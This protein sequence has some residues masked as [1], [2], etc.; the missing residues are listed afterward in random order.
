M[1]TGDRLVI[2]AQL[3]QVTTGPRAARVNQP[4]LAPQ[5]L[6]GLFFRVEFYSDP[7]TGGMRKSRTYQIYRL[8]ASA[9]VHMR[10]FTAECS[11]YIFNNCLA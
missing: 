8:Q 2:T 10:G 9:L 5:P 4:A 7:S 1:M 11:A 6:A 3:S